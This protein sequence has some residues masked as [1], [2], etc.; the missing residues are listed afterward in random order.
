LSTTYAKG[1]NSVRGKWDITIFP[2][3]FTNLL[4]F[5]DELMKREKA[6]AT[7]IGDMEKISGDVICS[8]LT[9]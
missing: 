8:T 6:N 2:L 9:Q 7:E 3:S 5:T 1:R 4:V